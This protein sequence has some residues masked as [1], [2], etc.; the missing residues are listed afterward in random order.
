M[1]ALLRLEIYDDTAMRERDAR[2][3]RTTPGP[4]RTKPWIARLDGYDPQYGFART[5]VRGVRDYSHANSVGSRGVWL[6]YALE[7]GMYEVNKHASWQ[8]TERYFIQVT[9]DGQYHRISLEEVTAW[10][11]A[12]SALLS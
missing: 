1:R 6:C 3:R 5:F 10:L 4:G 2:R 8:R 11:N 12:I 9:N 7:P